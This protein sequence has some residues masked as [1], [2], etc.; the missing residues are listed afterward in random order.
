MATSTHAHS[1]AGGQRVGLHGKQPIDP[2]TVWERSRKL[3]LVRDDPRGGAP[4]LDPGINF[5]VLALEQMG[6]S[7]SFSC[8]GHPHG[9]YI[10]FSAAYELAK[11]VSSWGYFSIKI[12]GDNYWSLRFSYGSELAHP[13]EIE[14][15]QALNWAAA[16]WV[17][18]M[19]EAGMPFVFPG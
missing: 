7:T 13:T 6:A 12:E 2:A 10:T 1:A 4:V 11:R 16:A 9:F 5:F 19:A 18:G 8:E 15:N 17:K 3:K 14:R